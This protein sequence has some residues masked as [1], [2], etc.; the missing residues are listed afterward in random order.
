MNVSD[1]RFVRVRRL[2]GEVR[3]PADTYPDV[4]LRLEASD[5]ILSMEIVRG[6]D[7]W[8]WTAYVET[9]LEDATEKDFERVRSRDRRA[10]AAVDV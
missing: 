1:R 7:R 5:R 2:D 8:F 6:F 9:L 10:G 3:G 4:E